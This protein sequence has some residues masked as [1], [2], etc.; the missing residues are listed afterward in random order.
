[1]WQKNPFTMVGQ[2]ADCWLFTYQTSVDAAKKYLPKH[3][4]PVIFNGY[5][6]WNVVISRLTEMR[7]KGTPS[8]IGIDYWHIAYRLYAY[9]HTD[10][11]ERIEGLY[12][13]RSDCNSNLIAFAGNLLTDFQ[14]RVAEIKVQQ[15]DHQIEFN[16]DSAD[17]PAH[18]IID[19]AREVIRPE[20]SAFNTLAEAKAAL[21][22]RPNG[23]SVDKEGNANIVHITRDED[24]WQSKL[25]NVIK[26][27]WC[28]FDDKD[29]KLEICYQVAPITYQWNRGSLYH[30]A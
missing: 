16:I 6:F 29:V 26:D 18:I 12:F 28:F 23:I 21:K 5:A 9:L 10:K 22:Y 17:A 2:I 19:R 24:A 25:V 14:L 20:Y 8:L 3:L 7:P 30:A 27:D 1:M 15:H 4:Q 13:V 11:G